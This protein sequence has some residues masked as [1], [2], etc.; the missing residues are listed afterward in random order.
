MC[1]MLVALN[2]CP[3]GSILAHGL[4]VK[5]T[6]VVAC[7]CMPEHVSACVLLCVPKLACYVCANSCHHHSATAMCTVASTTATS[8]NTLTA[9]GTNMTTYQCSQTEGPQWLRENSRTTA[10]GTLW[11]P[12]SGRLGGG[13]GPTGL[14]SYIARVPPLFARTARLASVMGSPWGEL[15]H[16]SYVRGL[17]PSLLREDGRQHGS[18]A[19]GVDPLRSG[20]ARL[21][22]SAPRLDED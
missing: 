9:G 15:E 2:P 12:P 18:R 1:V 17:G 21:V 13:Y 8:T 7:V 11:G 3:Y 10:R 5:P 20:P 14:W 16:G 4:V 6:R 22:E 19:R